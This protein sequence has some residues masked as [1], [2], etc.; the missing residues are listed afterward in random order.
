MNRLAEVILAR[1]GFAI[2][3]RRSAI[4][5]RL[6][7][8]FLIVCV[9]LPGPAAGQLAAFEE[10]NQLYQ[11]GDYQAALDSYLQISEAG[12]ESGEAYYNIGNAYFKL[13]ELGLAIVN[14]QR[15]LRLM[16]RDDDV[17]TNLELANSLTADE[18]VPLP[19]T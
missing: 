1:G 10:G 6:V 2:G 12:Y 7:T 13:G 8:T 9:L 4:C 3:D 14:Y 17:R 16:P 11:D 19:P 18:I 5:D 15:A